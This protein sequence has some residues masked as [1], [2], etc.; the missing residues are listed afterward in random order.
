MKNR[1][2]NKERGTKMYAGP[3]LPSTK[4]KKKNQ[5]EYLISS[6]RLWDAFLSPLMLLKTSSVPKDK[7]CSIWWDQFEVSTLPH[8]FNCHNV[9]SWDW[10]WYTFVEFDQVQWPVPSCSWIWPS[11]MSTKARRGRHTL[12]IGFTSLLMHNFYRWAIWH[13]IRPF[14]DETSA[15]HLRSNRFHKSICYPFPFKL[16]DPWAQYRQQCQH[17]R[18]S[19]NREY[20]Q[21]FRYLPPH[22]LGR[23]YQL[24]RS[25]QLTQSRPWEFG[26]LDWRAHAK[27][28]F[29]PQIPCL[30][31]HL[32][33]ASVYYPSK[34]ATFS[35]IDLGKSRN[36]RLKTTATDIDIH[37]F[38]LNI[39]K[40]HDTILYAAQAGWVVYLE[41]KPHIF[42]TSVNT[43]KVRAWYK[44]Q[45]EESK[46]INFGNVEFWKDP[47][48]FV[49][50]NIID[51]GCGA[52]FRPCMY[53]IMSLSLRVL[54]KKMSVRIARRNG[55]Y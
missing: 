47:N 7:Y 23:H 8:F 33:S 36:W 48:V 30:H 44:P 50:W 41:D 46:S 12:S 39:E 40:R 10:L 35:Y 28:D 54:V 24:Q 49:A 34:V 51:A 22:L 31:A 26:V 6:S 27:L 15:W 1:K 19:D 2:N 55:K 11:C 18:Q 16:G 45:L 3:E 42:S 9:S 13:L 14:L 5:T 4:K 32:H 21:N 37:G 29:R 38:T 52:N 43:Q 17:P 53:A 25:F 20:H